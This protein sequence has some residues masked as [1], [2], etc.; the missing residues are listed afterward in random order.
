MFT[1]QMIVDK[2]WQSPFLYSTR[3]DFNILIES[4]RVVEY[5]SLFVNAL[6]C[7]YT[8]L[9]LFMDEKRK[10]ITSLL[11]TYVNNKHF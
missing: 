3:F 7:T 11:N 6:L 10:I 8:I 9:I 2:F 1:L 5:V 4:I